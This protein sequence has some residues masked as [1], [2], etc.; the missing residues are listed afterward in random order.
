[1]VA[2]ETAH[3]R[4]VGGRPPEGL[5]WGT[6]GHTCDQAGWIHG[7]LN[8]YAHAKGLHTATGFVDLAKFYEHVRHLRLKEQ[9]KLHGY[10]L[11]L[12]RALCVL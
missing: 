6:T 12:L 5:F 11:K 9:A 7:V 3:L 4:A 8:A 2:A 1:M 10:N